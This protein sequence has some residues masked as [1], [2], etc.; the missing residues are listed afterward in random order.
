MK[1]EFGKK[2]QLSAQ[3]SFSRDK[4]GLRIDCNFVKDHCL[5]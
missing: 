5:E 3:A 2:E 4:F 1:T